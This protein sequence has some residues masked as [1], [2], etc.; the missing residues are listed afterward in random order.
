MQEYTST[1]WISVPSGDAIRGRNVDRREIVT[2]EEDKES[3]Y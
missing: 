2:Q 3:P 1:H